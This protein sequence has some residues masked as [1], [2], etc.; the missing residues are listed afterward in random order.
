MEGMHFGHE[1][2]VGDGVSFLETHF[3]EYAMPTCL[4]TSEHLHFEHLVKVVSAKFLC[5]KITIFSF[6]IS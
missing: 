1:Y 2:H 4:I 6:T 3:R 5:H